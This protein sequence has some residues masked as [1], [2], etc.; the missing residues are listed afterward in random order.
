MKKQLDKTYDPTI[1]KAVL[2]LMELSADE[3]ARLLYEA[4]EKAR[5]DF[6]N[7][8]YEACM[9]SEK[10]R[11]ELESSLAES[12]STLAEKDKEIA[13]LKAQLASICL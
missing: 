10:A 4:R 5:M 6:E 9:E 3:E 11:L 2:R 7:R 8:I 1:K 13:E 12:E